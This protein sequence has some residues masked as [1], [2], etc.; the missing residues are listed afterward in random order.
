MSNYTELAKKM[1]EG[2]IVKAVSGDY[3]IYKRK[4]L[5]ENID[6]EVTLIKSVRD[7]KPIANGITRLRQF[8]AEQ[9]SSK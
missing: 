9:E 4:W 2:S 6:Q 3:V 1:E 5:Y 8:V 7:F